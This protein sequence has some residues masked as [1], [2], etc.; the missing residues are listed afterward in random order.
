[1]GW[2]KDIIILEKCK[3]NEPQAVEA[4][5]S[6]MEKKKRDQSNSYNADLSPHP[7]TIVHALQVTFVVMTLLMGCK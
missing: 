4:L 5:K 1:M 6:D 7:K 2:Q 3:T